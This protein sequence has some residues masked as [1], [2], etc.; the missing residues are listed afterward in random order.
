MISIMK[1]TIHLFKALTDET[2]LRILALLG[3]GE[4]CVCDLVAVLQLPQSTVSRHLASLKNGGWVMDRRQGLW[5]YYR[6]AE[7][8]YPLRNELQQD[9]LNHL[10]GLTAVKEDRERLR[11]YL[12]EKDEFGCT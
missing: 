9:I 1:R 11:I 4:L 10:H 2:R 3:Q 12:Q 8:S 6:L 7:D 5:S